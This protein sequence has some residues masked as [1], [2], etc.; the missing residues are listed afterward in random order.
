[1]D[2]YINFPA[3]FQVP[4]VGG[5]DVVNTPHETVNHVFQVPSPN[6]MVILMC[7]IAVL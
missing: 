1:M 3:C 7:L 5:G 4:A 6:F 2:E